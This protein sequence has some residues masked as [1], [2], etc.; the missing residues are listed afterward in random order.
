MYHR[1]RENYSS[2]QVPASLSLD[3]TTGSGGENQALAITLV[4]DV[5]NLRKQDS[6]HFFGHPTRTLHTS[7]CS[8]TVGRSPSKHPS[9]IPTIAHNPSTLAP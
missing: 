6:P 9:T 3:M 7:I 2:S 1:M 8:K 4:T 5:T